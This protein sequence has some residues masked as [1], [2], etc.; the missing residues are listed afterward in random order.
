MRQIYPNARTTPVVRAEI[1][2]SIK[3]SNATLGFTERG[4][5]SLKDFNL[6]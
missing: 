5:E 6:D 3:P 2:R 1:T 4:I